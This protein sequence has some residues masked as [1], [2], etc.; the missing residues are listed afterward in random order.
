LSSPPE[1]SLI[2]AYFPNIFIYLP[3]LLWTGTLIKL[4]PNDT[5]HKT[6][7]FR[8]WL[9]VVL[10]IT[11]LAVLIQ[12]LF[13]FSPLLFTFFVLLPLAGT[14]IF[15]IV[16]HPRDQKYPLALPL[17]A[18]IFFILAIGLALPF[19]W[20]PRWLVIIFVGLPLILLGIGI[21]IFDAF[22]EDQR[23]WADMR[24]SLFMSIL[25]A[26]LFGIQLALV[27]ILDTRLTFGMI[28]LTFSMLATTTFLTTFSTHLTK[29]FKKLI[30]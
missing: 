16:K 22:V 1:L 19:P 7:L 2:F 3:A 25:L 13:G 11:F 24:R 8:T 20:L 10:L 14:Y 6:T 12:G 5:Q 23:L 15:L 4:L 26:L 18:T 30:L 9:R 27:I 29:W 17:I 21:A 28:V